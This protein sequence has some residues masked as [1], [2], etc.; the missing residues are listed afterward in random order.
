MVK[1]L[2]MG[3][4]LIAVLVLLFQDSKSHFSE[5]VIQIKRQNNS[6]QRN[7]NLFYGQRFVYYDGSFRYQRDIDQIK[8]LI[9]PGQLVLSDLATSYYAAATLP[10]FVRNVQRH[11]GRWQ[12]PRW[13][14]MLDNGI[15]CNLHQEDS[16]SA[17][18]S[19]ITEDRRYSDIKE[20]PKLNYILVN[21]DVNN[22]NARSSCFSSRRKILIKH[23]A[24]LSTLKYRGEFIDLYEIKESLTATS[25]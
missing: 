12:S 5:A 4:V 21:K 7:W 14:K 3:S 25:P 23:I 10:V 17:F 13:K 22:K 16:F 9:T 15:A 8:N 18:K 20:Q 2:L 6:S 19:F 24:D 1:R 11:Q